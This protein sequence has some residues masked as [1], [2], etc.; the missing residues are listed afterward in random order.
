V[1]DGIQGKHVAVV[2][3][4][5]LVAGGIL[6]AILRRPG[7]APE[8]TERAGASG[9]TVAARPGAAS[10]P[11]SAATMRAGGGVVELVIVGSGDVN[12]DG[13]VIAEAFTPDPLP[14]GMTTE[15]VTQ[16]GAAP[17]LKRYYAREAQAR[18]RWRGEHGVSFSLKASTGVVRNFDAGGNEI[19]G[20]EEVPMWD[21]SYYDRTLIVSASEGL[22]ENPTGSAVAAL[23]ARN[24]DLAAVEGFRNPTQ[25]ALDEAVD[26]RVFRTAGGTLGVVRFTDER[27]TSG[28]RVS[29]QIKRLSGER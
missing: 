20:R 21:L 1:S 18:A 3:M 19:S 8:G 14:A 17:E 24:E 29:V 5:V 22:W 9:D 28:R 6:V 11:T 12:L 13:A 26:I 16:P 10:A 2:V 15:Q 7:G 25:A 27:G 4:T 23:L